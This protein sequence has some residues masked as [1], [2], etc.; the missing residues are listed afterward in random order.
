MVA[1]C[2]TDRGDI[3]DM[4]GHV[5]GFKRLNRR[6]DITVENV[7]GT[8]LNE[9]G[10][11]SCDCDFKWTG[12]SVSGLV[13]PGEFDRDPARDLRRHFEFRSSAR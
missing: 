10:A 6:A 11:D 1:Q 12:D 8:G 9:T 4:K 13:A 2:R 5:E 3:R 7:A